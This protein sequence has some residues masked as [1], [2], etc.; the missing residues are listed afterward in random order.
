TYEAVRL[1]HFEVAPGSLPPPP[2]VVDTIGNNASAHSGLAVL[3]IVYSDGSEGT[4]TVSCHLPIGTPSTVDEGI[5]ATKGYVNYFN[6]EQ[7]VG[8]VDAD[9]TSFHFI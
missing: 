1:V 2:A 3:G 8:G 7:P 9:R 6:A 5:N 4:L